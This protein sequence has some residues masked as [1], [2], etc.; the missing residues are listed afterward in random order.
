MNRADFLV[1]GIEDVSP[2]TTKGIYC[3]VCLLPESFTAMEEVISCLGKVTPRKLMTVFPPTK[4]YKGER[5]QCKDYFST[6]EAIREFGLDT[7][8]GERMLDFLWD[9]NERHIKEMI[10][11]FMCHASEQRRQQGHKGLMEAYLENQ[12]IPCCYEGKDA[13]GRNVMVNSI[14]EETQV[15]A[16]PKA[17]MPKW[18]KVIEGGGVH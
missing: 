1:K 9:Y 18:W 10:V 5:F 13:Y 14:T 15:I 2:P 11:K 16:K 12:G 17:Q 6:M 3:A 7:P 8:M 4:E